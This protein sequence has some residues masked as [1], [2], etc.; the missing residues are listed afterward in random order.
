ME[1]FE[2]GVWITFMKKKQ[3]LETDVQTLLHQGDFPWAK[4]KIDHI[5]TLETHRQKSQSML[6]SGDEAYRNDIL[7]DDPI[8]Q[9]AVENS[10]QQVIQLF[11]TR[12]ITQQQYEQLRDQHYE[13]LYRDK[14]WEKEWE[15]EWDKEWEKEETLHEQLKDQQHEE[16]YNDKESHKEEIMPDKISRIAKIHKVENILSML[17]IIQKRFW[18]EEKNIIAMQIMDFLDS[19]KTPKEFDMQYLQNIEERVR[20]YF[21]LIRKGETNGLGWLEQPT[22]PIEI[23]YTEAMETLKFL[24]QARKE[25]IDTKRIGLIAEMNVLNEDMIAKQKTLYGLLEDMVNKTPNAEL[26]VDFTWVRR[27]P[28]FMSQYARLKMFPAM[29]DGLPSGI[30]AEFVKYIQKYGKGDVE[31]ALDTVYW[32]KDE[33]SQLKK[34]IAEIYKKFLAIE[35]TQAEENVYISD[36]SQV[37]VWELIPIPVNKLAYEWVV[38]MPSYHMVTPDID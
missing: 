34:Q 7:V 5:A 13:K 30:P 12:K 3:Q 32:L 16:P 9:E 25:Q 31:K 37:F 15:K 11:K 23:P 8:Y 38:D 33:I 1:K 17:S 21:A 29:A 19:D 14:E 27:D 26:S 36:S 22:S 35:Q 28:S 6:W 2:S 4:T 18:E 20:N 10:N 24:I